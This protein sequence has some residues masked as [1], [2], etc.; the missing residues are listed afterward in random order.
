[1]KNKGKNKE[2]IKHTDEEI[3]LIKKSQKPLSISII[4]FSFVTML[5]AIFLF[6]KLGVDFQKSVNIALSI[7]FIV[8]L[9][10]TYAIFLV[11]LVR[12][13]KLVKKIDA[14]H[15]KSEETA[16]EHKKS[17]VTTEDSSENEPTII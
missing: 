16:K 7:V 5:N 4:V 11:F 14:E 12:F 15:K 13:Q 17:D 10:I 2:K 6:V 1:M 3:V 9:V 8:L